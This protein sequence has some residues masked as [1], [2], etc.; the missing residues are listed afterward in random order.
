MRTLLARPVRDHGSLRRLTAIRPHEQPCLVQSR[1][2]FALGAFQVGLGNLALE[3]YLVHGAWLGKQ[4]GRRIR[5]ET[6]QIV[7]G[8]S[9][10]RQKS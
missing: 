3:S 1:E 5:A 9:I 8:H 7:S 6:V 2:D 10:K 4:K